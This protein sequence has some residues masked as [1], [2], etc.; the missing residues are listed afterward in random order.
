MP[1][2]LYRDMPRK[3]Y[4]WLTE[5]YLVRQPI[6]FQATDGCPCFKITRF[7]VILQASFF[8]SDN[9]YFFLRQSKM[10][11]LPYVRMLQKFGYELYA[12]MGTGDFYSSQGVEV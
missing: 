4:L 10:E 9:D 3:Q 2:S 11:L 7:F 12:S 1:L 6:I 8:K 5:D